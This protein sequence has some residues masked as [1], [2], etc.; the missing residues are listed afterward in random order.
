MADE[1]N[2]TLCREEQGHDLYDLHDL[3][4][5]T[6]ITLYTYLQVWRGRTQ[7]SPVYD[8]RRR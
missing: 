6:S 7:K 4:P 1:M 8:P 2:F 5:G 3:F